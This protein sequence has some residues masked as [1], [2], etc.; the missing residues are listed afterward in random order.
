MPSCIIP[1]TQ[2]DKR[3]ATMP[4]ADSLHRNNGAYFITTYLSRKM[5]RC[6]RSLFVEKWKN[7]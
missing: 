4:S 2:T 3:R 6:F 7:I 5:I 1:K